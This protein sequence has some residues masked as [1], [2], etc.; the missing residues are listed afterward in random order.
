MQ[1]REC[2]ASLPPE[3]R[4]CLSCG[5]RVERPAADAPV[6]PLRE[7]LTR[8]SGFSTGSSGCSVAAAW[9]PSTWRTSSRSTATWPSRS[10][11]PSTRAR[12]SVRERFRR[13]A[14]TAARLSHPHIVPLHTFGEVSGLVYFVM[15]YV[16]G[17]SLAARL[18]RKGRSSRTRPARCSPAVCD[19]L[20]YAH[21]QGIVHR[22]IKPD[23]I[24]I[25]ARVGRAAP[26][27]FRHRQAAAR[28][29]AAHDDRPVDRDAALHVARAGAGPAGRR[30]ALGPVL[31]R[32]RRRTKWC[33]A[34][35]RSRPTNPMDALTQRLTSEPRPL[36]IPRR[37]ALHRI[38]RS[39]SCA[40]CR[41]IP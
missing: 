19:A 29:R 5:A 34:A 18:H 11:L 27:R 35:G 12:P 21:R 37:P 7:A 23:N 17:E 36:A 14:R 32:R 40:A 15:G 25:D 16:A 26:D 28:R 3:A 22:D 10:C 24:L 8:R 6:D 39:R 41:E 2:D 33:R 30:P 38:S 31:A 20:D 13:E 9:A 4:F 1:C